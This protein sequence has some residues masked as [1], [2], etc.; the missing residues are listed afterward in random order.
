MST[1]TLTHPAPAV[2]AAAAVPAPAP[3]AA[4]SAAPSASSV[5][6][7]DRGSKPARGPVRWKQ[8]LMTASVIWI[9]QTTVSTALRPL[10]GDW[11]TVLRSGAVIVP[12]V[13]LMVYV[14]MPRLTRA[15]SGWLHRR[16]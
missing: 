2:P 3:G 13:F 15:L 11:P 10:V 5:T 16:R 8:F 9:L 14:V 7:S 12:V 4:P 6:E 1:E